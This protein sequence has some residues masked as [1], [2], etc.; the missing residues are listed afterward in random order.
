MAARE[1]TRYRILREAARLF[2][3]KGFKGTTVAEIEAAAGLSPGSGALYAHFGTKEDVLRGVGGVGGFRRRKGAAPRH[4]GLDRGRPHR[5]CLGG[6]H[7]GR[8][9]AAL[10]AATRPMSSA[11]SN[12]ATAWLSSS[13]RSGPSTGAAR[14]RNF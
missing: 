4:S 9:D 5:R 6:A 10:S 7:A 3:G 1:T 11:D 14:A 12:L 8:A 13:A 2:A